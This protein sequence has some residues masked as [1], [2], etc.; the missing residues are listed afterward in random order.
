[1][2]RK[3][4][5]RTHLSNH[6]SCCMHIENAKWNIVTIRSTPTS[7]QHPTFI[8]PPPLLAELRD[9]SSLITQRHH[10]FLY[11]WIERP[12][13]LSATWQGESWISMK[14]R[15]SDVTTFEVHWYLLQHSSRL[16]ISQYRPAFWR[17]TCRNLCIAPMIHWTW[18]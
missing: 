17:I 9:S 5:L 15:H 10:S 11:L 16:S 8:S 14:H 12:Q 6:V 18:L 4:Y 13:V 7:Y 2:R 1:M 3:I